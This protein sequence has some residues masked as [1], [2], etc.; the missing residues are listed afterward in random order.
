MR[1][2]RPFRN[3]RKMLLVQG[4]ALAVAGTVAYIDI[5]AQN[6]YRHDA[7]QYARGERADEP[8]PNDYNPVR[9]SLS[10]LVNH[11]TP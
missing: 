5:R 4:I 8:N 3:V 6:S 7:E 9:Q 1:L 10:W 2:T 11:L